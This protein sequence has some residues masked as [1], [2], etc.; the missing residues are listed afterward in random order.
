M[1]VEQFFCLWGAPLFG[2]FNVLS[3]VSPAQEAGVFY[4]LSS[5]DPPCLDDFGWD[6]SV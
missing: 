2:R 6:Y 1:Y 4:P 3:S 5:A